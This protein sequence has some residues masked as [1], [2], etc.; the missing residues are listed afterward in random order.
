[1]KPVT[2]SNISDVYDAAEAVY[3]VLDELGRAYGEEAIVDFV[4]A[5]AEVFTELEHALVK[6]ASVDVANLRAEIS[7]VEGQIEHLR[8]RRVQLIDHF[9]SDFDK[10]IETWKTETADMHH[11]AELLRSEIEFLQIKIG[12]RRTDAEWLQKSH[13]DPNAEAMRYFSEVNAL[14]RD[15]QNYI[16]D[17]EKELFEVH[18]ELNKSLAELSVVAKLMEQP[19][20]SREA[21]LIRAPLTA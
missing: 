17:K 21:A 10:V 11:S 13:R 20:D 4:P 6:H 1:M 12:N 14:I 19:T 18:Q 15:M 9:N 5:I 3:I 7:H 8:E 16:A 2:F